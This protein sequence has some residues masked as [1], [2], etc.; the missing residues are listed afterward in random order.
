MGYSKHIESCLPQE[1]TTKP[2]ETME[3]MLQS[4]WNLRGD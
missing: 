3:T 1:V 2:I 4:I